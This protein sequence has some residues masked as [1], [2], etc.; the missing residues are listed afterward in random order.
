MMA[1]RRL[2]PPGRDRIPRDLPDPLE[3]V[4]GE[5]PTPHVAVAVTAPLDAAA[6]GADQ[7]VL[8][9]TVGSVLLARRAG[10]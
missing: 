5:Y 9:V 4:R 1:H 10:M 3:V 6:A 8:R 2:S 7:S